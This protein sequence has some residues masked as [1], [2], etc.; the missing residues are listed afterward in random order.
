MA[1]QTLKDMWKEYG[2][3]IEESRVLNI[4][5]WA[6]NLKCFEAI[7]SQKARSKLRML[8]VSKIAGLF[9]GALWVAF[10]GM[11]AYFNG[12]KNPFFTISVGVL[13][14]FNFVAIINYV[15]HLVMIGRINYSE[16]IT[17][18]QKRLASL[19]SAMISNNRFLLLQFPFYSTWFISWHWIINDPL[20]FWLIQFPV[21]ILLT[22]LGM[23]L[24]ISY[25]KKNLHK[26]WVRA[27]MNGA[28]FRSVTKALDFVNEIEEY[29]KDKS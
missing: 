11:L 18:T 21:V 3:K 4:Q 14:L 24:Y 15:R 1:D 9:V 19:Q 5:S 28:G 22:V 23:W 26:P 20:S 6:L 12:F 10:L 29:K 27:L 8:T 7:Q 25:S 13:F 16:N 2:T 17:D